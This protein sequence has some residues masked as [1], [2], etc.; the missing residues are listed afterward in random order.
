MI[1]DIFKSWH[2]ERLVELDK[3]IWWSRLSSPLI[4]WLLPLLHEVLHLVD[5][6]LH[7][8]DQSIDFFNDLH[9]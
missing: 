4:E 9:C 3:L 8:F 2:F 7:L 6:V 1:F 5:I